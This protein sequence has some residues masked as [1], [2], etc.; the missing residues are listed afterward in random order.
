MWAKWWQCSIRGYC[1][2][3]AQ[4]MASLEFD[5]YRCVQTENCPAN[6]CRGPSSG[7]KLWQRNSTCCW[8]SSSC[9][10]LHALDAHV[11]TARATD[12][13]VREKTE[14][15]SK[16]KEKSSMFMTIKILNCTFIEMDR[17]YGDDD[18]SFGSTRPIELRETCFLFRK[19]NEIHHRK[20]RSV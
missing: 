12:F 8:T 6:S 17:R 13:G 9:G 5:I 7:R 14:W 16:R 4:T 2:R 10:Q 3:S 1:M 20:K 11:S 19:G 18:F 15:Q